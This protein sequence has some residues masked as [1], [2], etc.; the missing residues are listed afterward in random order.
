MKEVIVLDQLMSSSGELYSHAETSIN[1]HHIKKG[2]SI[3]PPGIGESFIQ[4]TSLPVD[5]ITGYDE[6]YQPY[7]G[8]SLNVVGEESFP[9][10]LNITD[11]LLT[12]I[13]WKLDVSSSVSVD[14]EYLKQLVMC[15]AMNGTCSIIENVLGLKKDSITQSLRLSS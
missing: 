2:R 6:E 7:Y 11:T 10:I 14:K 4:D 1:H 15:L 9:I 3:I 5:V 12:E 8:S 13:L